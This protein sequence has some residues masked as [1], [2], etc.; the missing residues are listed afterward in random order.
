[1]GVAV[2]DGVDGTPMQRLGQPATPEKR[3]DLQGFSS[4]RIGHRR[5][6]KQSDAPVGSQPAERRL[7]LERLVNRL[8]HE[9]FDGRLPPGPQRRT[10]VSAQEALRSREADALHLDRVAVEDLH[11]GAAQN[12]GDRRVRIPLAVVVAKNTNH[13]DAHSRKFF[14][15][16]A[17]LFLQAMVDQVATEQKHIGR[18]VDLREQG[19]D[20]PYGSLAA[21]KVSNRG[22]SHGHTRC[23]ASCTMD[24]RP[25]LVVEPSGA[26]PSSY[27][28]AL[29]TLNEQGVPF[30]VGGALAI[31][32]YSGIRRCTKDLD[33][34]VIREDLPRALDTLE[35][36]GFRTE[37]AFPHWLAKA[38]SGE[39]FVDVIFNSGNGAAPVDCGWFE[40]ARR[41]RVFGIPVAMCPV[42][43]TIWSKAFVMERERFDGADVMHLLLA[44][45]RTLDWQRLLERFGDHWRVLYA[46]LVLFG[47]VFPDE[48]DGIP[49]CV[50]REL[51][52]R[53]ER[54][55]SAETRS[56]VCRGTLLS[57]EQYLPDLA[58]GWRDA[59]LHPEGTMSTEAVALW[60]EAIDRR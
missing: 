30:L 35:R 17:R 13:R 27:P 26:E 40:H 51:S 56:G 31:A 1:M 22:N 18:F 34:F 54:E 24:A 2:E 10:T 52:S 21:V 50:M 36:V 38:H 14:G 55:G 37:T 59:R 9:A 11:S 19:R 42:E 15:Q 29:R 41:A 47:F 48:A 46:H 5:V 28:L 4:A 60:T 8:L 44:C 12:A 16:H 39:Y 20:L 53:V 6:V 23:V 58:R 57:R 49:R 25:E 7:E 3:V 43:E 45:A 32:A 33:L